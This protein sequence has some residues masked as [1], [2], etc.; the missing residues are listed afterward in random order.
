MS[1]DTCEG[2][3]ELTGDTATVYALA[4]VRYE[5]AT[6][7]RRSGAG[8]APSPGSGSSRFVAPAAGPDLPPGWDAVLA[9]GLVQGH[10]P[11]PP[12][13]RRCRRMPR[14]MDRTEDADAFRGARRRPRALR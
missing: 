12:D 4:A 9:R 6:A 13:G 10:L 14:R 8:S 1:P 7:S 3:E 2:A 11:T 5:I